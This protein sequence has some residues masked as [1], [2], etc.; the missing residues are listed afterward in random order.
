MLR[1]NDSGA[2]SVCKPITGLYMAGRHSVS[3]G[4]TLK[5]IAAATVLRVLRDSPVVN[6][7]TKARVRAAVAET[8]Y[9]INRNAQKLRDLRT[10]VIAL[11]VR[12]PSPGGQTGLP[13]SRLLFDLVRS[14]SVR[15]E[16][17]LLTLSDNLDA[18]GCQTMLASKTVDGFVFVN[19]TEGLLVDHGPAVRCL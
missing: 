19:A 1:V 5:D 3:P 13:F 11:C 4:P 10:N 7:D 8:G 2:R 18:T 12:P 17:A 14:L 16:E 15:E 6:S 9:V